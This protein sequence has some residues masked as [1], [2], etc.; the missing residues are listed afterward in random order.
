MIPSG[1]EDRHQHVQQDVE[2]VLQRRG[3]V[4]ELARLAGD[5]LRVAV[6]ADRRHRVHTRALGDEGA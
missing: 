4:P 1:T 3:R 5:P 2:R 6:L